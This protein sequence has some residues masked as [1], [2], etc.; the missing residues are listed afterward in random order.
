MKLCEHDKHQWYHMHMASYVWVNT[1]SR[2]G[3]VPSGRTNLNECWLLITEVL[4]HAPDSNFTVSDPAIILHI[5]FE[6]YTFE[7]PTPS[8]RGQ[9]DDEVGQ[10]SHGGLSTTV[11]HT[12]HARP[13]RQWLS[14][15]ED[16]NQRGGGGAKLQ[17]PTSVQADICAWLCITWEYSCNHTHQN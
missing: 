4:W 15:R 13:I 6:H 1:D 17:G 2:Y 10:S 3:L 7:I 16:R 12:W 11:E 9:W 14:N 8:C 5:E